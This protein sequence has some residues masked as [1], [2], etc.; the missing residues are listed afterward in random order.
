MNIAII[1]GGISGM[2]TALAI[3]FA[4][5]QLEPTIDF[6]ALTDRGDKGGGLWLSWF[7]L[8]L[9]SLAQ[10]FLFGVA[11]RPV[12]VGAIVVLALLT[13]TFVRGR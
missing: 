2:A 10:P 8:Q 4:W 3:G 11:A 7:P 13:R 6:L 12:L 9:L 1:G 5:A